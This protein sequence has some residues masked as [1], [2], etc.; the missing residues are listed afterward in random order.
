MPIEVTEDLIR[1]VTTKDKTLSDGRTL[2]KKGAFSNL[3]R[4]EDGT[5]LWGLCAGSGSKPYEL[6]ID[7]A[8]DSPVIRCTCPVKPPPCKHTLGLL[9][10]FL[11]QKA[12][13]AV[14]QAPEELLEKRAKSV[15]RAEKRAEAAT[16]PREVNKVA[17]EKKT[18]AQRDALD[19]LE[20]LVIDIASSGLGTIDSKKAAKLVEQARQLNDAYLNGAAEALRRLAALASAV[21][22]DDDDDDIYYGLR[23][24]G[25]DLPED[26]RHRLMLR[27]LTRLWAM[28]KKGQ[29]ALDQRLEEGESE[30][31]ADA[32]VEDL[33]GKI[34]D[35]PE[36]KARGYVK[37]DLDL[38]ELADERYLDNVRQE[39]IEE[40][41]LLDLADGSI[42][43]D[44]KFRPVAALDKV[45]EKPG[46]E[47]PFT[48]AE[49][50]IYPGFVNRRLRWE[51]AAF[52]SRK[53]TADDF[54]RIHA[55]AAVSLEAAVARY[56]EQIKNPLAPGE[57]MVF[58]RVANVT[59]AD[60][61]L[62]VSDEKGARLVL[63]DSP[64]ARYRS[65]NNLEM[66]AGAAL[67][68]G[69]LI[70]PASLL[71]RL[72][73]GLVDDAI[74]GQPFALVVGTSHIRLGM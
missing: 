21:T 36:L 42:Y 26:L 9:V 61:V 69:T 53:I 11:D 5:L 38:F 70:Q 44:R 50:G 51:I 8:G 65:T 12:K 58:F 48:V 35:L 25:D 64:L 13:F 24:P 15:E 46:Y 17:L 59:K 47:S 10:H 73:R 33:L 22:P 19:L 20:T 56:K 74:Y 14:A 54:R 29:K 57:A 55:V 28:V 2:S 52:K 49:A 62:V 72:Y 40:G 68:N 71:V 18:K 31:E 66:A 6:S 41:Y 34:W 45:P 23:E 43:V 7:L 1:A 16:K 27:H 32:V 63:L 4:L 60:G 30:S 67:E 39:R 37:R 3:K